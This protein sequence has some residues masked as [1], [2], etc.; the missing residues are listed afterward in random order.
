[1]PTPD[2]ILAGL[3]SIA[4]D[5]SLL[6]AAWHVYYGAIPVLVLLGGRPSRRL[7]GALLS[8]PLL[9]VSGLAWGTGNP[10]NG[11]FFAIS[12]IALIVI[13]ARLP[14]ES[15]QIAPT[16]MVMTGAFMFLVGW[17]YP[18][19][20]SAAS[21][22]AYLYA[23]PTG[24]IPCPTLSATIGLALVASGV[25]SA[26]WMRVLGVTG[27]F[28]GLFGAA[29]LGVWIDMALLLGAIS[30]LVA[31]FTYRSSERVMAHAH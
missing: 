8:L 28:Y 24:L 20:L 4:N 22:L 12:S 17:V 19:F 11:A 26:A 2:Q 13:A 23:A 16:W 5:W 21:P 15:I 3:G 14:R 1:M 30:I 18:H 6:A 25:G 7:T 29:R 10:F 9:S 27:L 31:S